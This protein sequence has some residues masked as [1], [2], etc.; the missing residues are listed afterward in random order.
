M[1][2][3][4]E[5][6]NGDCTITIYTN[7]TRVVS[8]N[9]LKFPLN[10]DIRVSTQCSFGQR[11]DGTHVL[12]DFC[13]E[14]A[15]VNGITC[16]YPKLID[17][18]RG[19]PPIELAIGCNEF[20]D[21]LALFLVWC[22]PRFVCNLTIN[23][24]HLK[25]DEARLRSAIK[26]QLI[27]GLGVSYRPKFSIPNWVLDYEHTVVHI[28]A[29]IDDIEDIKNKQF[30][31]I[32]VLGCKDFGYNRGKVQEEAIMHWYRN[33]S[34]LFD[35]Q[36]CFDNLAVE[37]LNMKRFFDQETWSLI[38]QGEESIYIDAANERYAPSSRSNEYTHW[39]E[40][41]I[42]EFYQNCKEKRSC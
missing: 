25:R 29:G 17:K 4:K 20:T 10:I 35:R 33:I 15:K 5:Y 22:K 27:Y 40:V 30:K 8:G 1:N 19:L 11:N 3:L 13:H 6:T 26:N 24:G 18:L 2:I 32:L 14:S 37:Q 7:G 21:E 28:I 34:T 39:D 38:E 9:H 42:K 16:N 23:S 36:V 41:G 12:C 31:K